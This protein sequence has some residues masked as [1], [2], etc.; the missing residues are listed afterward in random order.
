MYCI[1][2]IPTCN[3]YNHNLQKQL[4]SYKMNSYKKSWFMLNEDYE[5]HRINKFW[6]WDIIHIILTI[7]FSALHLSF[8]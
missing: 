2:F 4:M 6:S 3:K 5:N 1:L 7:V 8:L